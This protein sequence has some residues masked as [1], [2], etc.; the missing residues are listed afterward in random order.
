[1]YPRIYRNQ[2]R[3]SWSRPNEKINLNN[4]KQKNITVILNGYDV[5]YE[6]KFE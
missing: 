5:G 3:T 6:I 4:E 2:E 1:M